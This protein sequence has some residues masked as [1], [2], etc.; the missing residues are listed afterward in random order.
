MSHTFTFTRSTYVPIH[1]HT[2]PKYTTNKRATGRAQCQRWNGKYSRGTKSTFQKN[3]EKNCTYTQLATSILECRRRCCVRTHA[4]SNFITYKNDVFASSLFNLFCSSTTTAK[5]G[6]LRVALASRDLRCGVI[7]AIYML[8]VGP[9]VCHQRT[10]LQIHSYA[11]TILYNMCASQ[12]LRN[13]D[14]IPNTALCIRTIY[15]IHSFQAWC[16]CVYVFGFATCVT[17]VFRKPRRR[18]AARDRC[19][20]SQQQSHLMYEYTLD[21]AWIYVRI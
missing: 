10:E 5:Y 16:M 7:Y 12:L 1:T 13:R 19:A 3:E 8:V 15:T 20:D 4:A 21:A 9:R 14:R 2:H 11:K 17:N 6:L 18:S